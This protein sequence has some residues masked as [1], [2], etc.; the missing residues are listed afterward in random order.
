[1]KT[2]DLLNPTNMNSEEEADQEYFGMGSLITWVEG[3]L[4]VQQLSRSSTVELDKNLLML[5]KTLVLFRAVM[6][7]MPLQHCMDIGHSAFGVQIGVAVPRI[8]EWGP[9]SVFQLLGYHIPKLG[10]GEDSPAAS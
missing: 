8:Q 9:E 1:M 7:D 10:A 2:A 5:L 3:A 4:A 6:V